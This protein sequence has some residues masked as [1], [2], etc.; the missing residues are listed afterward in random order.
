MGSPY[1]RTRS[2]GMERPQW[3]VMSAPGE[4]VMSTNKGKAAVLMVLV[5]WSRL[6]GSVDPASIIRECW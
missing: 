2:R 4:L 3:R 5:A 6:G 1:G